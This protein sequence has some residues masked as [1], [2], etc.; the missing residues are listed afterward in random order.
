MLLAPGPIPLGPAPVFDL[1]PE[2]PALAVQAAQ[3]LAGIEALDADLDQRVLNL[4]AF[5][6]AD[7]D[8]AADPA[9]DVLAGVAAASGA[10]PIWDELDPAIAAI[11][12]VDPEW[13][14][15]RIAIPA[16]AWV[17]PLAPITWPPNVTVFIPT[18]P[19]GPLP[20][21]VGGGGV[22]A[23][24]PC[25]PGMVP[26]PPRARPPAPPSPAPGP[27]GVGMVFKTPPTPPGTPLPAPP[28]VGQQH[29]PPPRARVLIPP[30]QPPPPEPGVPPA[31]GIVFQ[32]PAPRN[33]PP[34]IAPP[35][36]IQVHGPP[37]APGAPPV[38][39][40]PFPA[41]FPCDAATGF[42]AGTSIPC[43]GPPP[44][45]GEPPQPI[46]PP[47]YYWDAGS[48]QCVSYGIDLQCPSGWFYDIYSGGCV[49]PIP[50]GPIGGGG[51]V[52]PESFVYDPESGL[53]F[54]QLPIFA[55]VVAAP[56]LAVCAQTPSPIPGVV[57]G[58]SIST[59]GMPS[60]PVPAQSCS[61][62][63]PD[64]SYLG[65]GAPTPGSGQPSAPP[66]GPPEISSP[67]VGPLPLPDPSLY[68][69]PAIPQA[70]L[71]DLVLGYS[72]LMHQ[73][74]GWLLDVSG[75]AGSP[76]ALH[77]VLNGVDLGITALGVTDAY[78]KWTSTS[79]WTVAD[80]GDWIWEIL[81]GGA[82]SN[83]L[84]FTVLAVAG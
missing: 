1:T 63:S 69:A 28:P 45:P 74:D 22:G 6:G 33:V 36:T 76:V 58:L 77:A 47:G 55:N 59:L 25:P 68:L 13:D 51:P 21:V 83:A 24:S 80:V 60:P 53:C 18:G 57:V 50:G 31:T 79:A 29:L 48:G 12:E 46:C 72:S 9:L 19:Y 61:Q 15:A 10:D 64:G 81:V 7:P 73:G 70:N 11:A 43:P 82:A 26:T 35:G 38:I 66:A 16:E 30:P 49:P 3:D 84:Q 71:I 14:Y 5:A 39:L 44:G 8:V 27:P 62:P 52:C 34:N 56:A 32:P 23:P 75:A 54:E 2:T 65:P 17:E 78:G 37:P 41:D 4:A 42:L 40:P 20:P 67:P